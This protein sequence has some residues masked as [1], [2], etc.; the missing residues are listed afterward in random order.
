MSYAG[1]LKT[2]VRLS[3]ELKIVI[4]SMCAKI[5]RLTCDNLLTVNT[6]DEDNQ[7]VI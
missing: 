6:T 7:T 2:T 3:I 5:K 1:H 4:D